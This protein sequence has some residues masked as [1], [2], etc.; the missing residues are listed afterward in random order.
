LCI[1]D[2]EAAIGNF[3]AQCATKLPNRFIDVEISS[4]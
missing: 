1:V 3:I 4:L 2:D